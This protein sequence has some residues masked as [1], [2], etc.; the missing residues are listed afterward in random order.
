MISAQTG[1][2]CLIGKP[3]GH[4]ISPLIHNT[5]AR[6]LGIDMVYTAFKVEHDELQHAVAG[7]HALSFRGMNVTVPHKCDVIPYLKE[8]D[9]LA[10]KIGAVNTLVAC[11]GGYKGYNTDITGLYRELTEYGVTIKDNEII[12][13]GAGGASRAITYLC[14]DAGAKRVWLLNR[15]VD[16][17]EKLADEVNSYFGGVVV[18]LALSDYSRIPS[19]KYPVIQ[20]SSVGMY[21][22]TDVS[23]IEDDEFYELVGTGV[24]IIFNPARTKFM[25]LCAEHNAPAYN[26]LKMLLYQGIA[27]FEL[28]YDVKVDKELSDYVYGLMQEEMR[29]KQ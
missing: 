14:A 5:L 17:A 18:P 29:K 21:P 12:I 8:I 13:L 3:V 7:A 28:W 6:E 15:S 20:T 11:P 24:D 22:D 10:Q 16:K 19:G 2:C 25:K 9:P 4:S 23:P 26:G 1:L 27:A